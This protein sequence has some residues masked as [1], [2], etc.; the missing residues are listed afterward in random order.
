MQTLWQRLCLVILLLT[1][2]ACSS[3]QWHKP[4][5][6]LSDVAVT[7][8]NLLESKL[9]L[10]LSVKNDNAIDITVD[11]LRFDLLIDDQVM[12]SGARSEPLVVSREAT[13]PLALEARARTFELLRRVAAAVQSDGRV[14]YVLRGEVVLRDRGAI[15]FEHRDSFVVPRSLLAK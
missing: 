8:G 12:A 13:T 4:Q 15:P 9:L 10:K 6:S 14:P 2:S 1:L 5:V 7:G 3:L 11:S